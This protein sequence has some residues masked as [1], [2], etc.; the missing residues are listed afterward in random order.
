MLQKLHACRATS[1]SRSLYKQ[2]LQQ[3]APRRHFSFRQLSSRCNFLAE[4]FFFWCVNVWILREHLPTIDK[5][6][7]L[8]RICRTIERSPLFVL[9]T[10]IARTHPVKLSHVL[11]LLGFYAVES[12]HKGTVKVCVKNVKTCDINFDRS[13]DNCKLACKV[14]SQSK[15][16]RL[17]RF[18]FREK[19]FSFLFS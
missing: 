7:A 14:A 17:I 15:Q 6:L 13:R 12:R 19:V 8:I 5:W 1:K 18:S 10:A 4:Q 11:L 9:S 3:S 2:S 16:G